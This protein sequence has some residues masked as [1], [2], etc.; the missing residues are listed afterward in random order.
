MKSLVFLFTCG[1]VALAGCAPT[2]YLSRTSYVFNPKNEWNPVGSENYFPNT[3]SISLKVTQ[4]RKFLR[5]LT[6]VAK[7]IENS[8]KDRN[9]LNV[10]TI[11]LTFRGNCVLQPEYI[12][13]DTPKYSA[14]DYLEKRTPLSIRYEYE[15]SGSDDQKFTIVRIRAY[16]DS[17][18]IK[19]S[20]K[21]RQITN[22]TFYNDEFRVIADA[23]FVNAIELTP[24][25]VQ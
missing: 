4:T 23:L 16:F 18:R 10:S 20:E 25:E 12:S 3:S 11:S 1:V 6:E 21:S 15:L 17:D 22:S 9:T 2:N 8:C 24:Q 14:I 5:P 7:A 13:K 19:V